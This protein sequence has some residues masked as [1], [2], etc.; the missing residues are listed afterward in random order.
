MVGCSDAKF[1]GCSD[2]KFPISSCSDAKFPMLDLAAVM[3]SSRCL[4]SV[5]PMQ[6]DARSPTSVL[7]NYFESDKNIKYT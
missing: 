3:P 1:L 5:A 6:L 4:T 2:A 7:D